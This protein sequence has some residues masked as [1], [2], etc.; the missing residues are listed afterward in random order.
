MRHQTRIFAS[1]GLIALLLTGGMARAQLTDDNFDRAQIG[2][3]DAG[4]T[5]AEIAHLR[6]LG[7]LTVIR[8][9]FLATSRF[10]RDKRHPAELEISA[11]KNAPGVRRLRAALKANRV[12]RAALAAKG[13]AIGRI[14]AVDIFSNGSLR[15]YIL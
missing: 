1:A 15:V 7:S 11:Q 14:V 6:H 9:K 3:L 4:R 2:I 8:L 5:A 13:V 12:T 10:R